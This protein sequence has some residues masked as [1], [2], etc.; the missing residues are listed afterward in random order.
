MVIHHQKKTYSKVNFQEMRRKVEQMARSASQALEDDPQAMDLLRRMLGP[1][2]SEPTLVAEG[3]GEQIAGL[4]T[5]QYRIS[6]TPVQ[7]RVWST[8]DL[9]I[10]GT[11][12]DFLRLRTPR[13]PLIDITQ[14]ME[15]FQEIPEL[16]LRTEV[17][18][19][20]MGNILTATSEVTRVERGPVPDSRF[21]VPQ[22]YRSVEFRWE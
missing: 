10:P 3:P 19:R 2:A 14:V 5:Q 21:Q 9:Q 18:I 13:H 4:P 1:T 17:T 6:M 22:G 16:V 12:Y 8:P 11:Y 7:I 20:L 15:A